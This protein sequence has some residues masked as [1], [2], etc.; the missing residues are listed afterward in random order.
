MAETRMASPIVVQ[1]QTDQKCLSVSSGFAIVGARGVF[2]RNLR[3]GIGD[4]C[5]GSGLQGAGRGDFVRGCLCARCRP[6]TCYP[7]RTNN[8][9]NGAKTR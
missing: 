1:I 9:A 3:L 2:V 5:C 8:G 7:I 4:S 6:G